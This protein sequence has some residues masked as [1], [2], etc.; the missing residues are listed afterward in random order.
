LFGLGTKTV[1]IPIK[2]IDNIII[3]IVSKL[4]WVSPN[5][6]LKIEAGSVIILLDPKSK[7]V[8]RMEIKKE[9]SVNILSFFVTITFFLIKAIVN[10]IIDSSI[11]RNV[12]SPTFI[13]ISNH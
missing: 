9:H 4:I 7:N 8:I 12:I 11:V 5:A 10:R 1:I 2:I 13:L 6:S 3:L